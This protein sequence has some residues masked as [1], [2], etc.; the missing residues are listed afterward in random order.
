M[1]RH[2]EEPE[3]PDVRPEEFHAAMS[4]V[5][6]GGRGA[7]A[8]LARIMGVSPNTGRAYWKNPGAIPKYR[9]FPNRLLEWGLNAG[10]QQYVDAQRAL[11]ELKYAISNRHIGEITEKAERD[12]ERS[13]MDECAEIVRFAAGMLVSRGCLRELETLAQSALTVCACAGGLGDDR[14][15]DWLHGVYEEILDSKDYEKF[16]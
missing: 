15:G 1:G 5:I 16:S 11:M 10:Y 12:F 14:L 9:D 6:P 2:R 3:F 13:R 4:R 8:Q 7:G